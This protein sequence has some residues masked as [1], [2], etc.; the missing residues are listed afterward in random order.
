M[1]EICR[2]SA[3]AAN[4]LGSFF[5]YSGTSAPP[6][7]IWYSGINTWITGIVFVRESAQ[8]PNMQTFTS[9]EQ[10][11]QKHS[12][13]GKTILFLLL[14][15]VLAFVVSTYYTPPP[16]D[17]LQENRLKMEK[18]SEK[19][20]KHSN[21]KARES[22]EQ[23]YEKAKQEFQQWDRKPNK[24]PEEKEYVK[25]LRKLVEHLRKKKD[26]TGENHSQKYKGN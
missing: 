6:V 5:V 4:D 3:K 8:Q 26:F 11:P 2:Q 19:N 15:S 13:P 1:E 18:N 7:P 20:G 25:K 12:F 21:P 16:P 17:N 14:L 24:T 9:A 10:L 22:A 23:Q